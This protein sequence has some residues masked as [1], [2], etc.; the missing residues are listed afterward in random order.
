MMDREGV[1]GVG[2]LAIVG[3]ESEVGAQLDR[4]IE[5]GVT[6]FCAFSFD[7]EPGAAARTL[8]FLGARAGSR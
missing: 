3:D 5:I 1:G 8:E 4:L 2:D 6:D 7:P